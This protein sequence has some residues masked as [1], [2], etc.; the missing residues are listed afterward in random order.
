MV[1]YYRII[2]MIGA[3]GMGEVYLALDSKLN[4]K[5]ALKFLPPHLCQDEECRMRF[6]REAQAAA[7]LDHPNIIPVYEVDEYKGRPYFVMA[8]IEGQ[9]IKDYV[10]GKDLPIERILEIGI[11]IS[12]GLQAAHDKGITHRDIKPSNILIDSHG[13]ARIVDFGL[14]SV[15]GSEH[16]TKTGSTFG[17]IGYM[18]PEQVRGEETDRR[19]DLFSLGVVLYELITKQNPFKRDSEAATLKAVSDDT[20]HPVARYRADVPD[21]LQSVIDK[22]LEKDVKTR[23]QHADGML[24]DLMRLK[25]SLESGQST[26]SVS[27]PGSRSARTWWIAGAL[28]TVVIAILVIV[29]F[30]PL[31]QMA[32][33][34]NGEKKMLAVL[35][36]ENLGAPEDEY[37]A[38]GITDEITSRLAQLSGLGVI[39][40]TSAMQYKDTDKGLRQIGEELGV[41]YILEGT[42]RWDKSSGSDRVRIVPQLIRVVDDVHIWA[43]QYDRML[44]DIFAVQSSISTQ[45]VG[46]LDIALRSGEQNVLETKPTGNMEA[47]GLY[48]R[49]LEYG[50]RSWNRE[51]YE[52]GMQMFRRA[53]ELDSAFSSAYAGLSRAHTILYWYF[54]ATEERLRNAKVACDRALQLDPDNPMAHLALAQYYYHGKREYD[55]ALEELEIAADGAPSNAEVPEFIGYIKRRQGK[56]KEAIRYLLIAAELNPRSQ[57]TFSNLGGTYMFIREWEK[58]EEAYSRAISI[59]PDVAANYDNKSVLYLRWRG[60]TAKARGTLEAAAGI[61]DMEELTYGF[62]DLEILDRNY[63]AALDRL[64]HMPPASA[65]DSALYFE[66]KGYIYQLTGKPSLS[67]IYFDSTRAILESR[68]DVDLRGRYH[69]WLGQIYGRLDRKDDAIRYGKI[70]VE[71]LPLSLDAFA[72]PMRLAELVRIYTIV[73]EQDLAIDGLEHLFAKTTEV[74]VPLLRIDPIWDPLRDHPRF[75]ALMEKYEKEH[76]T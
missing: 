17:T 64:A 39:S 16:L 57:R 52:I 44:T 6:K 15:R 58:A 67:A 20:P 76:G 8:A 68:I 60:D 3:G 10:T 43:D 46:A 49:G 26:V 5:V 14:A 19:S 22:A 32:E 55:R 51:D 73:G 27:L 33:I 36:F 35:P 75:K 11:Q 1:S 13:R 34:D 62:V 2:E 74:T 48:L 31:E 63:Q 24:S 12:E 65:G 23:Y 72:G 41:D 18:S 38:D 66:R 37:F 28:V 69:G 21:G 7:K 61:V 47:Y 59:A 30:W 25:R 70:G 40:R 29:E 54:D 50:S 56:F 42:I 71:S 9:S 4:R 53:I 45:V